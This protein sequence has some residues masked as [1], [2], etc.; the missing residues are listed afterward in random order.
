MALG[1]LGIVSAPEQ[2]PSNASS[3]GHTGASAHPSSQPSDVSIAQ[4]HQLEPIA[5]VARRAGIPEEATV[6]YGTTKSK[7][8][9]GKLAQSAP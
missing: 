3:S 7:V 8:T 1:I 6:P 5:D 2:K 4:A 9:V